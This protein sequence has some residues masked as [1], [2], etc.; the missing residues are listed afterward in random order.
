MNA[1]LRLPCEDERQ[2]MAEMSDM[3][4]REGVNGMGVS[5]TL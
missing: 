1:P 5:M 2:P 4:E 3:K